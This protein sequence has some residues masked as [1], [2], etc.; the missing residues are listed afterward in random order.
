[1]TTDTAADQ[2]MAACGQQA[3]IF[4]GLKLPLLKR[5]QAIQQRQ[6][7]QLAHNTTVEH[8]LRN[9]TTAPSPKDI[10]GRSDDVERLYTS[11]SPLQII[12]RGAD[13][14]SR[15][16]TRSD[17]SSVTIA[18][19]GTGFGVVVPVDPFGQWAS[20]G[21]REDGLK[22]QGLRRNRLTR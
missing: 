6:R 14:T 13:S 5:S 4:G 11:Y 1:M 7:F 2:V 8:N 16:P 22:Y 20:S 18:G 9:V 15:Q 17:G 21:Q 12:R 10:C 3:L 19:A